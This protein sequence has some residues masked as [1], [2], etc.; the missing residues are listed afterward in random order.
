[1]TGIATD[2]RNMV[3][4]MPEVLLPKNQKKRT[5]SKKFILNFY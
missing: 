5:N 1:M 3:K 2:S 4:R